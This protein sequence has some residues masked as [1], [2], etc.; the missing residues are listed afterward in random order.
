MQDDDC[1]ELEYFKAVLELWP[2][3]EEHEK[4]LEMR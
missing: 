1:N 4:V 2:N 3:R